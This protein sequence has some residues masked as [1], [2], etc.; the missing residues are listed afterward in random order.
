MKYE[1]EPAYRDGYRAGYTDAA[2]GLRLTVALTSPRKLY[3]QGYGD[4]QSARTNGETS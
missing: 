1:N 2:L 4:G 3:A